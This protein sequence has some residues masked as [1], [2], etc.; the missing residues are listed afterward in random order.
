[1]HMYIYTYVF[2]CMHESAENIALTFPLFMTTDF[3]SFFSKFLG[4]RRGTALML[5]L[6]L[7]RATYP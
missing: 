6:F 7:Y 3:F 1:M 5:S 4:K 2:A